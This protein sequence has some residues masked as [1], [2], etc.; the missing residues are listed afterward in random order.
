EPY[1]MVGVDLQRVKYANEAW[2]Y[3][4]IDEL[5]LSMVGR[6]RKPTNFFYSTYNI[7]SCHWSTLIKGDKGL[8][9]LQW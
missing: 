4:A 1:L 2:L 5:A 9:R 6:R 7:H 8:G 3:R